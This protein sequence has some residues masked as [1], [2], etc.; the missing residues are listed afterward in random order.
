[1][2]THTAAHTQQTH[3]VIKRTKEGE[4]AQSL[5]QESGPERGRVT[6][7]FSFLYGN[8]LPKINPFARVIDAFK[9]SFNKRTPTLASPNGVELKP[10]QTCLLPE[11]AEFVFTLNCQLLS[12]RSRIQ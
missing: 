9:G 12:T 7:W 4:T 11:L 8:I 5:N 3:S 10:L 6:P 1:M 2:Y